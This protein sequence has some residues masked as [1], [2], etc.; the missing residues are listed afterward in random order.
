[1]KNIYHDRIYDHYRYPRNQQPLTHPSWECAVQNSSCGDSISCQALV[2]DDIV[3]AISFR[4]QGCA[5][6]V[7]AMSLLSE[8]TIGMSL[9]TIAGLT[10]D[11]MKKLIGI[12]LG[13]VRLKCVLLSWECMKKG[14]EQY[15]GNHAQSSKSS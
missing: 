12:P 3:S 13:P 1:M 14:I 15:R 8:K 7:A 5:L 6:S 4:A 2:T 11:Q 9:D 10:V